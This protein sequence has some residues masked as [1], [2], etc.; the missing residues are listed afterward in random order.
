MNYRK[1]ERNGDELSI[2]GFGCMRFPTKKNSI[3]EARTE[4]LIIFAI[5]QG[6]NYFDTAFVYNLDKSESI[7]GKVL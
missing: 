2:L 5:E 3:D 4:A 6:V 7:L 1:N